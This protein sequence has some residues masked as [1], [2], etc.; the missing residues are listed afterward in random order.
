MRIVPKIDENSTEIIPEIAT[1]IKE[2]KA[3]EI[4]RIRKSSGVVMQ[5]CTQLVSDFDLDYIV[6]HAPFGWHQI[7]DLAQNNYV[8]TCRFV[9]EV[10]D[11]SKQ[12]NVAV[13]ILYHIDNSYSV[14]VESGAIRLLR[15]LLDIVHSNKVGILLENSILLQPLELGDNLAI[16]RVFEDIQDQHLKF[17]LDYCHLLASENATGKSVILSCSALHA[18]RN[19]HFSKTKNED[20]YRDVINTHSQPH[21]SMQDTKEDLMDLNIRGVDLEHL[22]LVLEVTESDYS[23]RNNLLQEIRNFGELKSLKEW[24]FNEF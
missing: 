6:L 11:F 9:E 13:D 20:G 1:A 14:F 15:D 10:V 16:N 7:E 17:C 23:R 22:N 24:P 21:D 3:V 4:Q 5:T 18:I 19:V 12:H 2:S 8:A